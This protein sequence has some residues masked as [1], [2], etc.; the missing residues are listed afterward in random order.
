MDELHE[1]L[2]L[3]SVFFAVAQ[4]DIGIEGRPH[5]ASELIAD[6]YGSEVFGQ[7]VAVAVFGRIAADLAQVLQIAELSCIQFVKP[8][9]QH[10]GQYGD[11][12]LERKFDLRV[13][14]AAAL[15]EQFGRDGDDEE[16]HSGQQRKE[17][18]DVALGGRIA[19][20]PDTAALA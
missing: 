9:L 18:L 8:F 2:R 14:R 6:E 11:H 16:L 13:H 7:L 15:R 3:R 12:L 1:L 17:L 20:V 19:V 4:E 5:L 10:D